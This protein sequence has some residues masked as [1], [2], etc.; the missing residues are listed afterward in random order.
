MKPALQKS[1][2]PENKAF[3]IKHLTAP[4]FDPN[5]HF[6]PEYQLFVVL[7]GKGTRFIG[8]SI[9]PFKEGDMVFTGPDVPHIWRSDAIY[10]DKLQ[11]LQTQGVVVYFHEHFLGT[12]LLKKEEMEKIQALFFRARSGLEIRGDTNKCIT[13]MMLQLLEVH[14]L[15]SLILLLQ[16]LDLLANSSECFPI[17]NTGYVNQYKETETARM[18][19]VYEYVMKNFKHR[20]SLNEVA[21]LSSMTPT[22]FSRYF[23]MRAN[24]PFSRFVS[25][26]RVGNA[27]KLLH[28][29]KLN[30]AQ[31]CYECGFNTLSNFNKQ[32]KEIMG[33]T[34]HIYK[35]EYLKNRMH[36]K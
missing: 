11:P 5:W 6:H 29:D 25:E 26:V 24:K 2:I 27:C 7:E 17:A 15:A 34:P 9:R 12:S 28:E 31:T 13:R 33:R 14:G 3:V 30:I 32:F 22:S 36:E 1:P 20:I 18:S 16:I 35:E 23:K 10:F 19:K 8:D 21:A 4:Y